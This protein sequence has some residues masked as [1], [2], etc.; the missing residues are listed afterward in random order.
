MAQLRYV[1]F[2]QVTT[3][4]KIID[5]SGAIGLRQSLVPRDDQLSIIVAAETIFI[6]ENSAESD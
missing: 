3:Q 5:Y 1:L 4:Q 6:L 2:Y